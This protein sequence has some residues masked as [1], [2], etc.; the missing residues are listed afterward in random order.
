[1]IQRDPTTAKSTSSQDH[2]KTGRWT[3]DITWL[4]CYRQVMVM[5]RPHKDWWISQRHNLGWLRQAS[6]G[7][8]RTKDWWMIQ[9]HNLGWLRQASYGHLRKYC[10][11]FICDT[12]HLYIDSYLWLTCGVN[13]SKN[14]WRIIRCG[15]HFQ[16]SF[17]LRYCQLLN[18]SIYT[19]TFVIC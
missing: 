4:D 13:A 18:N 10:G 2:T 5:S 14:R 1:M 19:M 7:Y 8:L 15:F 3:N 12:L 6:Y 9:Q 11:R 16:G 17:V